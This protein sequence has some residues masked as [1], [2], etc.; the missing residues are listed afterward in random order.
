MPG[1]PRQNLRVKDSR[2]CSAVEEYHQSVSEDQWAV[3]VGRLAETSSISLQETM[4]KVSELQEAK[5]EA[6]ERMQDT[7][8]EKEAFLAELER[9]HPA[10]HA[11]FFGTRGKRV[12]KKPK[13][14]AAPARRAPIKQPMP[15]RA[16][17]PPRAE[18]KA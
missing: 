16:E 6:E 13:S 12:P 4:E 1:T 18:N 3:T 9:S 11:A 5:R 8:E 7:A 15:A 14:A 17:M 10:L 2:R